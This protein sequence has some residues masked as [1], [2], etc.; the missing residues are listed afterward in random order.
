MSTIIESLNLKSMKHTEPINQEILKHLAEGLTIKEI[1]REISKPKRTIEWRI[2]G[3]KDEIGA[4]NNAELLV[5]IN[6]LEV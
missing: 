2:K 6:K 5:K 3:M 1:A 4:K